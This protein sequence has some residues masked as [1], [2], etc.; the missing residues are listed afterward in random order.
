MR[1][2]RRR[3]IQRPQFPY[4]PPLEAL[5]IRPPDDWFAIEEADGVATDCRPSRPREEPEEQRDTG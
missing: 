3:R 2:R 1:S 4:W 5:I